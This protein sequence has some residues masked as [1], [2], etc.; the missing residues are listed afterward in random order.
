[1]R[2]LFAFY[3]IYYTK[4]RKNVGRLYSARAPMM[5]LE[6]RAGAWLIVHE[7]TS[8]MRRPPAAKPEQ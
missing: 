2:C 6:K 7:H 4:G 5:A 8:A 3:E 1:M